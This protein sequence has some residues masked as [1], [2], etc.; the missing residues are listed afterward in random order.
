MNY[1]M[2][3]LRK[4]EAQKRLPVNRMEIDYELVTLY[5]AMQ[6]N[7]KEVIFKTKQRLEKLRLECIEA[8]QNI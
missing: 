5:D 1:V 3:I 8:E 6:E 4:K 7:D 2:E